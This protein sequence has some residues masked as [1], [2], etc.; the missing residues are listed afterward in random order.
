MVGSSIVLSL[1][2]AL[3]A[4]APAPPP[5]TRGPAALNA[6]AEEYWEALLRENPQWATSLGDARFADRLDDLSVEGRR[7]WQKTVDDFYRRLMRIDPY[8]MPP[9]DSLNH[10]VFRLIL[11]D[12]KARGAVAEY[13][14]LLNALNGP[15]VELPLLV[16]DQPLNTPADFD[17]YVRRLRAFPAQ[18]SQCVETLRHRAAGGLTTP[19]LLVERA[20]PQIRMHIVAELNESVFYAEPSRKAQNL[21]ESD[22]ERVLKDLAAAVREAVVP[23]YARLLG[24]VQDEYLPQCRTTIGLSALRDGSEAYRT[25]AS[26]H[27]SLEL[28]PEEIHEIGLSEVARIRDEMAK[29]QP[30][31]GIEGTLDQFLEQMRTDP[32]YRAKSAE[33]LVRKYT[34]VL[35]R[36]KPLMTKLFTRLPKADIVMKEIEPFRAASAPMAYYNPIPEDGSRP[37]YFY[38]NTHAPQD[39]SLFSLEALTYHE[40]VPGHHF[41]IALA[42]EMQNIPK[43]RR[44]GSFTAYVEGWALYAER[45]GEAIGGYTDPAQKFGQLNFEIWRACRLVVD[46]GMHAKGWSRAEAIDYML[47]NSAFTR[48]DV[49]NEI[50]RYIAWP[51]QALAY[52]LGELKIMSLRQRAEEKLG[53]AFDLRAFNDALLADGPLPLPLLEAR[54]D[55]WIAER[56]AD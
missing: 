19:R 26:V 44:H 24:F 40:A 36:T 2:W 6:L 55:A 15:H 8:A 25:M 1:V 23:A 41:Q 17:A 31:L 35:D 9:A 30:R 54:I 14:N 27:T 7:R 18:V 38:I 28:S 4:V 29:V 20:V 45:L 33:E 51:G 34:E 21:T 42:T 49:E 46:T 47:R 37:G 39:R 50:D 5:E 13:G 52:K 56:K 3:G 10:E 43:L 32:K 22:R 12:Q 16:A 48:L 11:V 53:A